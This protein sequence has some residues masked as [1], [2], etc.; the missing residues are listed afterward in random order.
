MQFSIEVSYNTTAKYSQKKYV[1]NEAFLFP[2][3][4]GDTVSPRRTVERS[5]SNAAVKASSKPS[6]STT[7][8]QLQQQQQ[9]PSTVPIIQ[10]DNQ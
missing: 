7:A 8:Q 5:P 10:V 3:L 9:Q 1:K 6:Q 2:V 4:T